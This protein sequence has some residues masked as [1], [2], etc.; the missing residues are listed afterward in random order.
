MHLQS[1]LIIVTLKN[2]SAG[3]GF[4]VW[5]VAALMREIIRLGLIEYVRSQYQHGLMHSQTCQ[6]ARKVLEISQLV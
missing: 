1:C 2:L 4:P 3:W 5:A 6:P